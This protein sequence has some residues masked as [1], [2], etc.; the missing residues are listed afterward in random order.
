MARRTIE[1]SR[2]L[3][4]GASSGIGRAIARELA[5]QGADLFLVARREDRLRELAEELRGLG[6]R[7]QFV[8]GDIT[9][10]PTRQA[11]IDGMVREFGGLDS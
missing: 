8:A 4:T 7:C 11:A 3:V 1:S 5:S 10:A 2:A 6:R 9:E